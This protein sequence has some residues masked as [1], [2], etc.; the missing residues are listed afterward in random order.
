M[1]RELE[2][3]RRRVKCCW[4]G[5]GACC[6]NIKESGQVLIKESGLVTISGL[7]LNIEHFAAASMSFSSPWGCVCMQRM[8]F[9]TIV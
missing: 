5:G 1:R 3:K 8:C 7:C 2:K 6:V 4:Q 9:C